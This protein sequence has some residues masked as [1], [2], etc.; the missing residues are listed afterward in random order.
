MMHPDTLDRTIE[1]LQGDP[2]CAVATAMV[3]IKE[4]KEYLSPNAVKVVTTPEGKVLYFSRSPIP[5]RA[6]IAPGGNFDRYFGFKHLGLYV[7]RK[8]VLLAFPKMKPS[9][10][11]RLEQLEQLRFLENGYLIKAIE[12][13]HDSIGIDTPEDLQRLLD[14]LNL[15]E[16]K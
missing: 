13:P 8:D 16:E 11:E 10:L 6:R 15:L 1:L 4:K 7:F 5:S 3:K 2:R 12:T 14:H 9:F